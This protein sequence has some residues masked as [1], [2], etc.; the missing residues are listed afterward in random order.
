MVGLKEMAEMGDAVDMAGESSGSAMR[1][2]TFVGK[3][4]STQKKKIDKKITKRFPLE[5]KDSL[6]AVTLYRSGKRWR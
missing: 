3:A 2:A 4:T 6:E 1:S 5:K